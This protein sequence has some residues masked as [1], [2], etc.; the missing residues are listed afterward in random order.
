MINSELIT[1]I[2]KRTLHTIKISVFILGC[3]F[4]IMCILSLTPAP[5]YTRAWLGRSL[6]TDKNF[7]PQYIIMLGGGGMP[8]EENLIR[9]YYTAEAATLYPN[10][11]LIIDH[12]Y[13]SLVYARMKNDLVL[14]G[15]DSSR[16]SFEKFGLN[17]RAQAL[18]TASFFPQIQHANICIVSSPEHIR[19]AI[20]TFRKAGFNSLCG[21]GAVDVDMNIDLTIDKRIVGGRRYIPNI[22]NNVGM[23]YNF[24]TYFKIEISCLREFVALTYYWAKDWI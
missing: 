13:D 22:D 19:R 18:Y 23:R 15:V 6:N 4:L 12:P 16:I 24:W 21:Y 11:H 17:T 20:L 8:G 1:Q 10:A 2:A 3:L 9:L 14:R 5:Y 7:A